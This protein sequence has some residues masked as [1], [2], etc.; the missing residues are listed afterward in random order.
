V[1]KKTVEHI[2]SNDQSPDSHDSIPALWCQSRLL[3]HEGL[4]A[5]RLRRHVEAMVLLADSEA[6][7]NIYDPR[8][9]GVD[10]AI[11]E[12]HRA[13][14]RLIQA[15]DRS[16]PRPGGKRSTVRFRQMKTIFADARF[17][18]AIW[19]V[20][21]EDLRKSFEDE[22]KLERD[23]RLRSVQS[24]VQDA[25]SFLERA[26]RILSMRRR[27][28]WW[29]TWFFQRKLKAIAMS[30][31]ATVLEKGTPIPF[32]SLEAAPRDCPTAADQLLENAQRMIR[33]DAYRLATIVEEYA[34][35]IKALSMRVYLQGPPT[36]LAERQAD[37]IRRLGSATSRLE[38][39]YADRIAG[40]QKRE[41][42]PNTQD[43]DDWS[44]RYKSNLLDKSA[45]A[46]IESVIRDSAQIV[47]NKTLRLLNI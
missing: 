40:D 42:A 13:E 5:S 26:E 47:A 34:D 31:W 19:W 10:R 20:D 33:I 43:H 9:R 16:I 32:L 15:D 29:T 14:V 8:R 23:L 18:S 1:A 41:P 25:L 7:L 37:M 28:V 4:C 27:N 45:A 11:I 30:A 3:M 36:T 12:L 39:L 24:L 22:L 46:Y 44:H 2:R 38:Q 21:G 17:D 35:C 6:A